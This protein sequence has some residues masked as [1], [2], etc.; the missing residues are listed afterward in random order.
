M[1]GST[2]RRL[3]GLEIRPELIQARQAA[4]DLAA[5]VEQASKQEIQ[6]FTAELRAFRERVGGY[7]LK[8]DGQAALSGDPAESHRA[9]ALGYYA[10]AIMEV[11][12]LRLLEQKSE[13]QEQV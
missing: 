12:K 3:A 7:P 1:A 2:M 9:A 13:L 11:Y 8:E 10:L 6:A 4:E 5:F